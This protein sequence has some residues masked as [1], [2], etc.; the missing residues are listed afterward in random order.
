LSRV[1]AELPED[2]RERGL[3][4]ILEQLQRVSIGDSQ[5]FMHRVFAELI[6]VKRDEMLLSLPAGMLEPYLV[7]KSALESA[8]QGG[9]L[10]PAAALGDDLWARLESAKWD[11]A[12]EVP[13]VTVE[14]D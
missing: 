14:H 2:I 8:Q 9:V 10:T 7:S 4:K 13:A 1:A 12:D 6:Y 5:D 11:A 3:V